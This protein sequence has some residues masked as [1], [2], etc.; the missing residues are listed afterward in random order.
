MQPYAPTPVHKNK[1]ESVSHMDGYYVVGV[2]TILYLGYGS[3][4]TFVLEEGKICLV[5]IV[6]I[7]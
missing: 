5:T 6:D 2:T 7:P 3:I 4:I 1:W